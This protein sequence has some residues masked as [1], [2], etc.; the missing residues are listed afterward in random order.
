VRLTNDNAR[1][2]DPMPIRL[3]GLTGFE[4]DLRLSAARVRIGRVRI[5]RTAVAASL[6]GGKLQVTVGE[7]QAFNGVITG[8]V[9]LAKSPG[10][11][12]VKS[13]MQFTD[14]DLDACLGE[15]IGLRRI[16]GKGNLNIALEGSGASVL[17]LTRNLSGTVTLLSQQGA[18]SGVNVE[19]VLRR[20]E[21]RPLSG[22]D[23]RNG[24]TPYDKLNVALKI[25]NGVVA[26]D[27][28]TVDGAAVRITLGGGASIPARDLDLKGTA[29]LLN[30]PNDV[31]FAL[32]FVVAGPWDDAIP[33]PDP[34]SLIQHSGAA[35]GLLRAVR[36]SKTRDAVRSVIEKVTGARPTE[37]PPV[38]TTASAPP[39]A[40]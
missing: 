18:L 35:S 37:P 33:L 32:P 29:S 3:E 6:R 27:D 38:P 23:L 5:G 36:D 21:R 13:D 31:A 25:V 26:V 24:R 10:G 8:S 15:L 19:Q 28:A 20:L 14:V 40:Q 9:T 7:A 16:E 22:A 17:N 4:L 12:E 34:A 39:P 2:W 11:A 1:E 30:G